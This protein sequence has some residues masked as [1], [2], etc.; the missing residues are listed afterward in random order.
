MTI[1]ENNKTS[2][3][4]DDTMKKICVLL[5]TQTGHDFSQYKD[6]TLIH[7]IKRR[8]ALHQIR[9][10]DQYFR[11]MYQNKVESDAL[12]HDTF[13]GATTFFH[14]PVA[15]EIIKKKVIPKLFSNETSEGVI[16]IWV[17]GCST[18]EEAYSIAILVQEY[19]ESIKESYKVQ[20]FATDIDKY[21][22]EQ[23]R[24][25]IFPSNIDIDVS[26]ERLARFFIHDS[27]EGFYHIRKSIRDLL[28]FSEHDVTKD[29]PFSEL[30]LISCRN[31]LLYMARD[32]RSKLIPLFHYAI[33]PG[34][35]LFMGTLETVEE[36]VT[37]FETVDSKWK[38]YHRKDI[39]S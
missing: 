9:K 23:A 30:N 5:R 19:M 34:G 36:F 3:P 25:A 4:T 12:F 1:E 39:H 6:I 10:P 18:G 11:F 27:K 17:C 35:F 33:K 13:I 38:I 32:L 22:I 26:P 28:V 24:S 2:S 31:T 16:R 7:R 15:F 20:I 14:D 37:T 8:M 29:T 21:S